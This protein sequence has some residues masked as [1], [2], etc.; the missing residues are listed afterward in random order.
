[1]RTV[2]VANRGE[3]AVRII[4][5]CRELGLATVAVYSEADRDAL[6]VRRA[7]ESVCIGPAHA[8]ESYLNAAALVEAAAGTGADAIHPGYG[9]LAENAVFAAACEQAGITFVGPAAAVIEQLGDKAAARRLAREA[10]VPTVPGT[11]G[12]ASPEDAV[13]AAAA[14]GYPVMVKAA[15]GGGG[16]G[17]RTASDEHELVDVV[18]AAGR[19]AEAAFG[20]GSL[21]LERLLVGARHVEV[22]VL[23]DAHGSTLH[24]Y[25][26]ECSMQRRRQKIL[27]ESPAPNLPDAVRAGMAEAAVRLS[28]AAGYTSAGTIEFLVDGDDYFFIEMNT[29]IQVEHPVTE[30]VTGLD[31]VKEQLHVAAGEPL[32]ISQ[33]EIVQRG[34]AIEFRINAEDSERAF[35]PSPGEVTALELPGG[36]GVRVDTALFAGDRIP[37]YYDSLIGKLIVWGRTR[38]EAIARGRRA[39]GEFRVEG[40]KTTIPFHL[41]LLDDPAFQAGTYDVEYLE[42]RV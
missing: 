32:G 25:E 21:Y 33:E 14:L 23:G 41:Q 29:R 11:D 1:V 15:A 35:M 20:D 30:M 28:R 5:S 16:R 4:R 37:P 31:L 6:H 42:R 38:D 19:E 12:I 27:E 13:E 9:F 3:I 22:Q 34:A 2:L 39:L 7:D 10:G 24:V 36:P 17:I 40:V 8:R 26:R 18:V